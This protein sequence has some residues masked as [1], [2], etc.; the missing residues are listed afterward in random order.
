MF[1][2]PLRRSARIAALN[3]APNAPIKAPKPV[4]RKEVGSHVRIPFP[5]LDKEIMEVTAI[6]ELTIRTNSAV[7][8]IARAKC[9]TDVFTALRVFRVWE[10]N[11][12]FRKTVE[13][14]IDELLYDQIPTHVEEAFQTNDTALENALYDLE[15]AAN[16]LIQLMNTK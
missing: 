8:K 4:D 15:C 3:A 1:T 12:S 13:L 16:Q 9:M 14:K 7:G 6:R 2:T 5:S 10:H 11:P